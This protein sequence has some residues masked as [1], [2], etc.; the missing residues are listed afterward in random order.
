MQFDIAN[1]WVEEEHASEETEHHRILS[2]GGEV[3]EFDTE[4]T[5]SIPY[6]ENA[7]CSMTYNA[8]DPSKSKFELVN[9]CGYIPL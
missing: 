5:Y 6:W 1:G 7:I 9:N 4:H 2:S 8:A 3:V